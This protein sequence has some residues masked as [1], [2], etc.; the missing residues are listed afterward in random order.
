VSNIT[1]SDDEVSFGSDEYVLFGD[2]SIVD[3]GA[4]AECGTTFTDVTEDG[5]AFTDV[6]IAGTV[7]KLDFNGKPEVLTFTGGTDLEGKLTFVAAVLAIPG[8]DCRHDRL[9]DSVFEIA[10]LDNV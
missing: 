9:E 8:L 7:C 3:P 6:V 4:F 10:P 2:V 5:L 1:W